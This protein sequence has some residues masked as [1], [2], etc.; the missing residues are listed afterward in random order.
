[1]AKRIL[2]VDDDLD[3]AG[4]FM[5]ALEEIDS[6]VEC[7]CAT[8]G[9]DALNKLEVL[10]EPNVIFMDINMPI[11]NGWECLTYLKKQDSFR[12]IPVILYSTSSHQREVAQAF[13]LG[14]LCF[15]S[16]P[17][18]FTELKQIMQIVVTSLNNDSLDSMHLMTRVKSL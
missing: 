7:Y 4:L 1:M 8:D 3:D 5:E 9:R 13:E 12:H 14:A 10:N 18:D 2:L 17:Y 16:K 6:T 15:F 11:M